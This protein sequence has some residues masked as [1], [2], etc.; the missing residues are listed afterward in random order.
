MENNR[1]LIV[2][3]VLS[4]MILLGFDHFYMKPK[5]AA[6]LAARHAQQQTTQGAAQGNLAG[7]AGSGPQMAVPGGGSQNLTPLSRE[8]VL[9][10][11][12]R[13]QINS[14]RLKGSIALEGALLDDLTLKGYHETTAPNSPQVVLAAPAGTDKAYY[15]ESGWVPAPGSVVAVPDPKTHW[16]ADSTELTPGK[17]LTLTWDNGQGVIF[18]RVYQLDDNYMFT[19]TQAVEN[20]SDKPLS[21]SPY[22]LIHKGYPA[23]GK[24]FFILHEGPIGV[25]GQKLVTLKYK[26]LDKD[27]AQT[28][29]GAGGWVGITDKYWLMALIPDQKSNFQ[30][31]FTPLPRASG[32]R[33]QVDILEEP[34]VPRSRPQAISSQG[35]RKRSC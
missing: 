26:D 35:P 18:K 14:P 1:N 5:E 30:G 25:F 9:A 6:E 33:Y 10:A 8:Q 7:L 4:L 27:G 17:P 31:R 3:F 16:T 19:V 29:A 13:V 34:L 28:E 21:L 22:S 12:Q 23:P 15:A 20:H 11:G 32:N 2:A 24:A